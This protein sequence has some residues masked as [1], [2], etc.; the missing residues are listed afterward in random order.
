MTVSPY[1]RNL[2]GRDPVRVD[3]GQYGNESILKL[4]MY[5]FG[6]D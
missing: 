4:I 1:T 5:R 2:A 3:H 6:L